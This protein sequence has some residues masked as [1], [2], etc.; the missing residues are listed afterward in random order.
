MSNS[1]LLWLCSRSQHHVF[2]HEA[3]RDDPGGLFVSQE[4]STQATGKKSAISLYI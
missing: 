2:L 3:L 4:T 1:E